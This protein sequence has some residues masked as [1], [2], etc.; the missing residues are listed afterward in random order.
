MEP[1]SHH[2]GAKRLD[3]LYGVTPSLLRVGPGH[4]EGPRAYV[5]P[6]A[7]L[8]AAVS[9]VAEQQDRLH[10]LRPLVASPSRRWPN[11]AP[12]RCPRR[13]ARATGRSRPA[14]DSPGSGHQRHRRDTPDLATN[15]PRL[16][17]RRELCRLW[18]TGHHRDAVPAVRLPPGRTAESYPSPGARSNPC[19]DGGYGDASAARGVGP[20]RRPKP[21]MGAR[22]S[23]L[24]QL[25][26]RSHSLRL[27]ARCTE[28]CRIPSEYDFLGPRVNLPRASWLRDRDRCAA[29]ARR[30][31][32][33][34]P[35]LA[36]NGETPLWILPSRA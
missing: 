14:D 28:S 32:P 10:L 15:R 33:P 29:E 23:P 24:A 8:G 20:Q 22:A 19:L 36:R 17:T 16:S 21:Q 11:A 12:P 4:R 7:T 1:R 18:D 31:Q 27:L 13:R 25:H 6:R 34:E 26:D 35:A 2:R 9:A 3:G 30:P 5:C